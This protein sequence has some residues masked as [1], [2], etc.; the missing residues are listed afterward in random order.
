MSKKNRKKQIVDCS[1]INLDVEFYKDIIEGIGFEITEPAEVSLDGNKK[2]S[3][4][5]PQSPL[6]GTTYSDEQAFIERYHC[7]CGALQ[8]KMFEGE[9]CNICHTKVEAKDPDVNV[10]GWISFGDNRVINPYYYDKLCRVLGRTVFSDIVSPKYKITTDGIRE[11]PKKEDYDVKPSSPYAG[12]GIDEFYN[13]YENILKYFKSVKKNKIEEIDVLLNEKSNVFTSHFPII[14]TMLRPQSVTSD[15]FYYCSIDKTINTLFRLAEAVKN[16]VAAEI[17][18]DNYLSR[19]QDK[20]NAMWNTIF[21]LLNG[22]EGF[23]RDK[24]LG[25]SLNFTSRNVIIPDP[26]L[27]DNEVDLSYHTFL[28]IFKFHIIKYLEC[29][30][31]IS[32]SKAE[33]IWES[34]HQFDE[35]VYD[36]MMDIV[37]HGEIGIFINRNPTLNYY[38][39]LLMKIRKV[40]HDANDYC[41]SVPLSILPGL[42]ADFDGDILNIIGLVNKDILKMFKKFEPIRHMETDRDTGKLNSLFSIN[43]G[44]L[45]DLY[46]FAT[47]GKTENDQPEIE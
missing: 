30:E 34:A 7:E 6:Y 8:S 16:G 29:L 37:E 46:Y 21:E 23:I 25:G 11:K 38:S 22:K 10:T 39:M 35:K 43:K 41:L 24:I 20:I 27:K 28:E 5:G 14:T 2:K 17:E 19:I 13:Q 36:V 45:I 40:K 15:T 32:E 12:I 33:D 18:R 4:Y 44:Q 31:G 26:T 3:L 47:I 9:T 42:N 1:R